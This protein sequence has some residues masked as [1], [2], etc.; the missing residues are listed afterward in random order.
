MAKQSKPLHERRRVTFAELG[1]LYG[2]LGMIDAGE[3]VP[4]NNDVPVPGQHVFDMGCA[5]T[6]NGHCGTIGCIG[7]H[8]GVIMGKSFGE[9]TTYVGGQLFGPS[10]QHSPALH[11]LFFPSLS[12]EKWDKITPRKAGKAIR[13]FL[14]DGKPRWAAV[15]GA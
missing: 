3:F 9:A 6:P 11:P 15:L 14:K 12:F 7:G 5:M 2:V 8:M 13:N 10:G 4:R 1:A